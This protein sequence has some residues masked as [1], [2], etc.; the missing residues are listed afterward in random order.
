MPPLE[1]VVEN[2][3]A[4]GQAGT[5]TTDAFDQLMASLDP[6]MAVVTTVVGDERSG[7]LVGF[8]CQ[9]SIDPPEYSVWISKANHTFGLVLRATHLAVHFLTEDD[10]ELARVFGT[11]TGDE[12]DKFELVD[13]K[14]GPHDVP[15]LAAS[16]HGLVGEKLSVLDDRGDHVVISLG[17]VEVWHDGPFTPLRLSDVD[18][19]SP[20]H[21]ADDHPDQP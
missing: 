20:G 5:V 18:D 9:S 3:A 16:A 11:L 7:C 12:V 1:P 21:D 14:P 15:V 8:H 2:L 19:L 10:H 13:W 6:A 4:G 17:P